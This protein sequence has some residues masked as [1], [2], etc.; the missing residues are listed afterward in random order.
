MKKT[1]LI[2]LVTAIML[3]SSA[4]AEP[5]VHCSFN[6]IHSD[7]QT[8]ITADLFTKQEQAFIQSSLFPD[9]ILQAESGI[10]GILSSGTF[11]FLSPAALQKAFLYAR[12][13]IL[14]WVK[15]LPNEIQVSIPANCSIT[16]LPGDRPCLCWIIWK[17]I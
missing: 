10:S 6:I 1:V 9:S 16:P 14:G 12:Q 13:D 8:D 11:L 15:E 4:F 5:S 2:L 7:F 17:C 3:F